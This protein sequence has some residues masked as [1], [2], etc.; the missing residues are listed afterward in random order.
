MTAPL[1]VV[2]IAPA[3]AFPAETR[4]KILDDAVRIAKY[5]GY[6]NAGLYLDEW[7]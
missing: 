4:Q 2:E 6:Q 1:K 3:P 5:V 7:R